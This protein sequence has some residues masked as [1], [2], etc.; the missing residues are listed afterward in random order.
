MTFPFVDSGQTPRGE[1]AVSDN[2]QERPSAEEVA[3]WASG[4]V[5]RFGTY[6]NMQIKCE[7]GD[8]MVAQWDASKL[9]TEHVVVTWHDKPVYAWIQGTCRRYNYGA[10]WTQ[11]LRAL[12]DRALEDA[13]RERAGRFLDLP[14]ERDA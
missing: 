3:K 11:Q 2:T 9:A 12:Y 6:D 4:A 10:A 14:D 5:Q 7:R 13:E 1:I 8:L